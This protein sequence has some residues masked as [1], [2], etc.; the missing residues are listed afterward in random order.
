MSAD[1]TVAFDEMMNK[2]L[3][4]PA[5]EQARDNITWI[6][7]SEFKVMIA[8]VARVVKCTP[9]TVTSSMYIYQSLVSVGLLDILQFFIII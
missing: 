6:S 8:S 4:Q 9:E 3:S 2:G 1:A 5:L 7:K